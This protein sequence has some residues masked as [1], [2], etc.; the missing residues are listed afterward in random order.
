MKASWVA[1]FVLFLLWWLSYLPKLFTSRFKTDEDGE[2]R[3]SRIQ[4]TNELARDGTILLTIA[5]LISF[6]G[7]SSVGATDALRQAWGQCGTGTNGV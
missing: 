6:A 5:V 4:R 3:L 2:I 1:I 7:R